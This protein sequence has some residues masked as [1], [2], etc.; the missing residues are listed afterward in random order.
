MTIT[1]FIEGPFL[2]FRTVFVDASGQAI[3]VVDA[4]GALV[5]AKLAGDIC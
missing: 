5:S 3:S 2:Y 1:L 4:A